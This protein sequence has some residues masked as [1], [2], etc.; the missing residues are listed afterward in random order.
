[1]T[2]YSQ[3]GITTGEYYWNLLRNLEEEIKKK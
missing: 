3:K 2:D 1:M